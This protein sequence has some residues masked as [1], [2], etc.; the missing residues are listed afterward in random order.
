MYSDGSMCEI[1]G[2]SRKV[3]VK[4]KCKEV[5]Q[6]N[7][8]SGVSHSTMNAV[9]LY[10]VEPKPCEY[11]LGVEAPFLCALID[12]ADSNGLIDLNTVTRNFDNNQSVPSV[13]DGQ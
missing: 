7:P 3:E 4:L 2:T 13:A 10:L 11:V 9:T 8:Q 6:Q 12:A 5:S 1:T